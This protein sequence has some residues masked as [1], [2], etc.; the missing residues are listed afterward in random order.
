MIREIR[1]LSSNNLTRDICHH[2]IA[3][4][5]PLANLHKSQPIRTLQSQAFL[6]F[7]TPPVI[8]AINDL[9]NPGPRKGN[10]LYES[11]TMKKHQKE[12]SKKHAPVLQGAVEIAPPITGGTMH[13]AIP[14]PE[15]QMLKNVLNS[16]H[17]HSTHSH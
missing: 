8:R 5:L 1:N 2:L 15:F 12:S 11:Q 17:L 14:S 16:T 9:R 6:T 4:F 7:A 10:A 3:T 13:S